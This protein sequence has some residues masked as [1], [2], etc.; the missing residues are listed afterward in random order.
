V[1]A[2]GQFITASVR[3]SKPFWRAFRAD[4]TMEGGG[5]DDRTPRYGGPAAQMLRPMF[6]V[7]AP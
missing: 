7:T 4:D 5:K 2:I 3:A 1:I 6:W